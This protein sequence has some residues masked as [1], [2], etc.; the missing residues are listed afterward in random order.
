MSLI[1]RVK[2]KIKERRDKL[3]NGGIN[4]IPSPFKRFSED[5]TGIEQG[6]FTTLTSFTK[7]GKTQLFSY[8]YIYE[9][10][11][12]AYNNRDKIKYTVLY[13]PLEESVE[14]ITERFISFLLN[15]LYNIRISPKDLRS[16]KNSK[17]LPQNILDLIES[18]EISDILEFYEDRV[19]FFTEANPTGIYKVCKQY[20]E[21]N[22][23]TYYKKGKYKDEFGVV[24][25]TDVFDRFEWNN[26]DEYVVPIIDTINLI[27]TER[28]M[29]V[30][31]SMDKMSEYAAKYL[32]NRYNM[33]PLFVQQQA[34][35]SENNEAFK[36]GRIRPSVAGLG[37]SKYSSRDSNLVLGLFSPA[38]FG[39]SEYLGYNITK[40]KDHIRFLEICVNRDGQMGGIVALFFDGA[41]CTFWE[42]PLPNNKEEME[43]VYKYVDTLDKPVSQTKSFFI[44]SKLKKLLKHG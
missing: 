30:K 4:S 24:H 38:R 33:S 23:H 44:F 15:K 10:L 20:A 16:T 11:L 8:I 1:N 34:F 22:G 12:Y 32:R 39:L 2:T 27:D 40:L 6:T 19:K 5:F 43:K 9:A 31:Q 18:K 7:G 21:D 25:E 26:P 35:E 13:F 42:L 37:D 17:P 28:G 29:T 14:R 36:L 41:T 3:L